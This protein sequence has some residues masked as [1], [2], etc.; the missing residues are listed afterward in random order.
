[1][2]TCKDGDLALVRGENG[3]HLSLSRV[4]LH[5]THTR[6]RVRLDRFVRCVSQVIKENVVRNMQRQKALQLSKLSYN[7]GRKRFK[8]L[9]CYAFYM[10]Y[11]Y[12]VCLNFIGTL[13]VQ[14]AKEKL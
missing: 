9:I 7:F 1:M 14:S 12:Y 10:N 4:T 2:A 8:T 6:R 5:S 3:A 13:I 11:A